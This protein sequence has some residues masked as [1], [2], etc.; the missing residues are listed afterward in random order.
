MA[1]EHALGVARG[2]R[3]V[4]QRRGGALVELGPGVVL[5]LRADE[6]VVAQQVGHVDARHVRAVGHGDE[7]AHALELGRELLD[8]RREAGVEEQH[9]VF[10]VVDD[11]VDLLRKEAR[12]HRVQHRARTRHAVVQRQVPVGVPRQRAHAV[13]GRHAQ[14]LHRVGH[15]LGTPLHLAVV[16][17]VHRAFNGAPDDLDVGVEGGRV[18]DQRRDQQRAVLHQS[19]HGVCLLW[20]FLGVLRKATSRRSNHPW[21]RTPCR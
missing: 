15:L 6:L 1:V 4:A 19:E 7:G 10:G 2:A 16:G 12:V 3:G 18:V 21:A 14:R 17:A 5:A 11:V 9:L 20:I 8:Q 13:A